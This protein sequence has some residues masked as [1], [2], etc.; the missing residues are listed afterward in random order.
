MRLVTHSQLKNLCNGNG[1]YV[2]NLVIGNMRAKHS[3]LSSV[4]IINIIAIGAYPR[5][6]NC[7]TIYHVSCYLNRLR[8]QPTGSHFLVAFILSIS[9]HRMA[10]YDNNMVWYG[11]SAA[12]IL[13]V[14]SYLVQAKTMV[15]LYAAIHSPVDI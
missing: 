5:D 9:I 10:S 8:I 14:Q 15:Y 2:D 6:Y 4:I 7:I 1:L 3:L 12:V 13:T 11:T